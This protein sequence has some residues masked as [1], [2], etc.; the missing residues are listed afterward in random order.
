MLN[1]ILCEDD[2]LLLSREHSTCLEFCRHISAAVRSK[3][4]NWRMVSVALSILSGSSFFSSFVSTI[5]R[6]HLVS[7]AQRRTAATSFVLALDSVALAVPTHTLRG[8]CKVADWMETHDATRQVYNA[9]RGTRARQAFDAAFLRGLG[10][11]A[12]AAHRLLQCAAHRLPSRGEARSLLRATA[13]PILRC[14]VEPVC[15]AIRG[16]CALQKLTKWPYENCR[17]DIAVWVDLVMHDLPL[18]L[19]MLTILEIPGVLL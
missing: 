12:A 14:L 18:W 6:H 9:P 17:R 7:P 15:S 5:S 8:T 16:F 10:P 11:A 2:L 1:G 19:L 4:A 13:R 3:A